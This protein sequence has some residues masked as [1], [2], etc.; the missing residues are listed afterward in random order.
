MDIEQNNLIDAKAIFSK[1]EEYESKDEFKYYYEDYL[2]T[3]ALYHEAVKNYEKAIELVDMFLKSENINLED[4]RFAHE[5]LSEIF[6]SLNNHKLANHHLKISSEL[7]DSL[8]QLSIQAQLASMEYQYNLKEQERNINKLTSQAL[9][10]RLEVS[11]QK[12]KIYTL[13]ASLFLAVIIISGIYYSLLRKKSFNQE[14][15][16]QVDLKTKELKTTLEKL[17]LRND[18]LQRFT[19]ATSH[20]LQEPLN[21]IISFLE[22]SQNEEDTKQISKY[23]NYASS[24]ATQLST[25]VKDLLALTRLQDNDNNPACTIS[26]NEIISKVKENLDTLISEKGANIVHE[27]LP[28]IKCHP[29]LLNLVLTNLI[30]NGI[31][32]NKSEIPTIKI[33]YSQDSEYHAIRILDNGVGIEPE[34]HS[35]IF[36]LFYRLPFSDTT[37]GSG[38]GL[39]IVKSIMERL[40]GTIEVQSQL[41]K[42]SDFVISFP[43]IQ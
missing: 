42:G 15:E 41:Q 18:D 33:Q 43:I 7:L 13:Y 24:S 28:T 14:L 17:Q 4:Q 16:E 6:S 32:Y 10:T 25:F 19:Y 5:L 3:K 20:D 35:K 36:D 23:L 37:K 12:R 11:S 21:N 2:I 29:T 27:N 40:G 39:A 1:L 9:E 31:K 34:Y 30:Q 26:L 8:N 38:L 22:L